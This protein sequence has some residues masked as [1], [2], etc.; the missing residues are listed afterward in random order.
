MSLT[1]PLLIY[2]PS[3]LQFEPIPLSLVN[4]S[5][6]NLF[7]FPRFLLIFEVCFSFLLM[8]VWLFRKFYA[9]LL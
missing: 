9:K 3:F 8:I 1:L 7:S 6:Y 2:P 4:A 5:K